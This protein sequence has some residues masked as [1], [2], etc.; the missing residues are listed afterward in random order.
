MT[1]CSSL[2]L[3]RVY[4]CSFVAEIPSEI[5]KPNFATIWNTRGSPDPNRRGV[6]P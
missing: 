3:I 6:A 4:S 1:G 2:K 5:K